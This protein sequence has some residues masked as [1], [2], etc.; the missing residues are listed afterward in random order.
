MDKH[1]L[2]QQL[3]RRQYAHGYPP[4]HLIDA[5]SD[6]DMID[7]YITCSCCGEKQVTPQQLEVAV[8]QARDAYHSLLLCD[9]QARAASRGHIQLPPPGPKDLLVAHTDEG[10]EGVDQGRGIGVGVLRHSPGHA[11]SGDRYLPPLVQTLVN[12]WSSTVSPTA[13]D[14]EGGSQSQ[15]ER[16]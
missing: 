14:N 11:A 1:L 3:R 10:D 6:D 9:E 12:P 13:P 4:R 2:A 15:R 7:S 16:R 8:A 5:V